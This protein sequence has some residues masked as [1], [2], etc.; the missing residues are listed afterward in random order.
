MKL[1]TTAL[2]AALM[3]TLMFTLGTTP[4][5]AGSQ[6][7]P[8]ITDI[9]GDA[10][11]ANGQGLAPIDGIETRP[12]SV[13]SADLRAVWFET[14]Y[15]KTKTV[16]ATGK[17]LMVRH[18]ATGLRVNIQTEAPVHPPSQAQM[19]PL[20]YDVVAAIGDCDVVFQLSA[21]A[22][23]ATDTVGLQQMSAPC[24]DGVSPQGETT[25]PT[26]DAAIARLEFPF[27]ISRF[28]KVLKPTTAIDIAVARTSRPLPFAGTLVLD[29]ALGDATFTIGQ[30]VPA[31][32]DCSA[33]PGHAECQA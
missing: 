13:D 32:I 15:A 33:A 5:T 20:N 27:A 28:G 21:T 26:Y 31:D 6:E 1:T 22:A 19:R 4:A 16:D 17:V 14:A 25:R 29:D 24:P 18:F 3:A 23:P 7:A 8:E 30:D 9:A 10:G 12:A 2:P 11:G